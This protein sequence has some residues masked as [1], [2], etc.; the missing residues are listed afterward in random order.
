MPRHSDACNLFNS[1]DHHVLKHRLDVLGGHCETEGRD[2]DSPHRTVLSSLHLTR[3]G[4]RREE[5]EP[6]SAVERFAR[7]AELGIDEVIANSP[8]V[9][10][11]KV[12]ELFAQVAQGSAAVVPAVRTP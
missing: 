10:E 8:V 5:P 7:P 9:S 3:D 2:L 1:G 4:A 6:R 11:P 12:F